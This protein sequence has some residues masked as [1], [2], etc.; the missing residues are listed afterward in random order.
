MDQGANILFQRYKPK[1]TGMKGKGEARQRI[2]GIIYVISQHC[3]QHQNRPPRNRAGL[4]EDMLT[5]SY[6]SFPE[7]GSKEET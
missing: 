4:L 5:Q 1:A 7:K 2:K 6:A 3:P